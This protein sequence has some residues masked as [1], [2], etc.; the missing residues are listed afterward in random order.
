LIE[1]QSGRTEPVSASE[2]PR[3]FFDRYVIYMPKKRTVKGCRSV[4]Q[5]NRVK[6]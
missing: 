1:R 3:P 4:R 6:K 5:G 2:P